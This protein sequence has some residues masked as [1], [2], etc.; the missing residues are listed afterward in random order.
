MVNEKHIGRKGP[1]IMNSIFTYSLLVMLI[2]TAVALTGMEIIFDEIKKVYAADGDNTWYLGKGVKPNT[3]FTYKIQDHDTNEGQPFLMNIYFKEFNPTQKY[4][5]APA[6][7]VDNQGKVINGTFHLSDLDLAILGSSQI[8]TE[9]SPYRSAYTS[10]LQWL[11]SFV[12]KSSPQ[13]LTSAY[14]GRTGSIG[15]SPVAPAG[16]AKVTVPAGTFDTTVIT[17]HKGVDNNVWIN[18]NMPYPIK[19]QTFAD[20]TTGNPPVQYAFDLL[21]TAQGPPPEPKSQIEIPQ[22]PLTL[23]TGRGTYY[24]QLLWDPKV[25]QPG[26]DTKFGVLF[27]DNSKSLLSQVS[28]SFKVTDS[29]GKVIQDLKNQ[30]APD[31]SGIQTVRFEKAGPADVLVSIDAVAGT[32][33]GEFIENVDFGVIATEPTR[34]MATNATTTTN[35]T[36]PVPEF[37]AAGVTVIVAA[38]IM[39]LLVLLTRTKYLDG[40]GKNNNKWFGTTSNN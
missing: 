4:W 25:I 2:T 9:M 8:P 15:G 38:V 40:I 30:K 10:S 17:W 19:A 29:S 23:Q 16:A 34:T 36:A 24:I 5:I 13:S 32:P 28:Y 6:Y 35:T 31:G 26:K 20:V 7:V 14:W 27:M 3:Y 33:S 21:A 37:P 22:P 1:N 11:S 18:K 39:S 12:S